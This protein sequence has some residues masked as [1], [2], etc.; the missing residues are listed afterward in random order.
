MQEDVEAAWSLW[1]FLEQ[2]GF[3]MGTHP[4][5]TIEARG[6]IVLAPKPN[7]CLTAK[8]PAPRPV[9]PERVA[10]KVPEPEAAPKGP[11]QPPGPPP[12][13]EEKERRKRTSS[14]RRSDRTASEE[15][16]RKEEKETRRREAEERKRLWEEEQKR[17]HEAAEKAA[18]A[19]KEAEELLEKER[20]ETNK[21]MLEKMADLT[22]ENKL[23]QEKVDKLGTVEVKEEQSPS[24]KP[25]D[26]DLSN[27]RMY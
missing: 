5:P 21:K 8:A 12:G 4:G 23:L 2:T 6:Q 17:A 22:K 9:T 13:Y 27:F 18:A 14:R 11:V 3:F 7:Q 15:A 19:Q 26:E 16:K 20:Q 10:E 1:S 25:T 24:E